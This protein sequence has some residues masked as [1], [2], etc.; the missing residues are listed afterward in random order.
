MHS[1]RTT[2]KDHNANALAKLPFKTPQD[3][4]YYNEPVLVADTDKNYCNNNSEMHALPKENGDRGT[5]AEAPKTD[6]LLHKNQPTYGHFI[7]GLLWQ[8]IT[9]IQRVLLHPFSQGFF[10]RVLLAISKKGHVIELM[11]K[12]WKI[13]DSSSGSMRVGRINGIKHS[14]VLKENPKLSHQKP[15]PRNPV[16]REKVEK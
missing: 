6:D 14:I 15:R 16:I 5:Q 9:T 8:G 13:L 7:F 12:H 1:K 3:V 4:P 10:H 2:G 11:L